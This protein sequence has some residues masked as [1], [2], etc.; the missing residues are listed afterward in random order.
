LTTDSGDSNSTPSAATVIVRKVNV[1][2]SIMMPAS[3]M[4]IMMN[5]RWVATSAPDN[6]R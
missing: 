4:A 6:S 1:G 3:T 2:R 5:E